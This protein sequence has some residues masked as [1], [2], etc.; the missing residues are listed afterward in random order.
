MLHNQA[1]LF[2]T[3]YN[4]RMEDLIGLTTETESKHRQLV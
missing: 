2:D 4:Y 1:S 3:D